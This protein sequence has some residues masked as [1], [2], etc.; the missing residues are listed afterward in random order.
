MRTSTGTQQAMLRAY[1]YRIYP[2]RAQ[3]TRLAGWLA[4]CCELY[5][6]G[7]QERRD[8]YRITRKTIA[9]ND[10]QNQLPEIKAIRPELK[11]I[12]SQVLQDVLRHLDKAFD[13]FFRMVKAGEKSGFPRFRSHFRYNS[14]TFHRTG[15]AIES[16]KLRL[17]KIGRVKIKLHRTIEGK[18]KTLTITRR[19]TGKWFACFA[20]ECEPEPLQQVSDAVG[21]DCGLERFATLSTGE[22]IANPRFFRRDEKRLAKAQKK[23]SAATKAGQE[24]KRQ[25]TVVA[26]VHE[27]IANKRRDF[28]HKE[29]RKLVNRFATIV[30][31]NL[32][33]RG[34]LKNHCLA[35]SISDAAW[36]QLVQFTSYKAENAGRCV[37]QVNPRNTSQICSGCGEI[38]EKDLSV[39]IHA[40]LCCG[41]RLHRDHNAAI[42]ILA[43]GLQSIGQMTIKA[44]TL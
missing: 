42:N 18:I 27:S 34:M 11:A 44:A 2:S 38:M 17:S 25:Q 9:C 39:R 15:F 28:A 8:A 23:L 6:A 10:Q 7:L 31:E 37:V 29:S 35:K 32:N 40:C 4:L 20:V 36:N 3:K 43:L 5:N 13:S 30:F 21:I 22:H 19:S 41:L 1:K 24:R 33:I 16:G 26:R 12:H 14:F